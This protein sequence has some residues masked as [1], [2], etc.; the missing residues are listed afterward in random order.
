MTKIEWVA[1]PGTTPETW[2]PVTGCTKISEGC[3]NCYAERMARRLA[4]RFGYPADE[5]F[6]VTLHPSRLG[7]PLKWKKPR[8]IFICSMSDLFHKDVSWSFILDVIAIISRTPQHTYL[9]LTKRASRMYE[10]VRN[11]PQAQLGNIWLGVTAENQAA[12]DERIPL[13]LQTPAAVR[14]VSCEPLLSPVLLEQYLWC[15]EDRPYGMNTLGQIRPPLNWVIV[16]GE[17]GS[18]ARPMHPDWARGIR[19]QCQAAGVKFFFKQWGAWKK[20][21]IDKRGRGDVLVSPREGVIDRLPDPF[22]NDA[23]RDDFKRVVAMSRVGKEA[24]SRLLDGREWNEWPNKTS[25]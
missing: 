3:R 11:M 14:F 22:L 18:G 19:D 21:Q 13:L 1:R 8:T 2:N 4:G 15:L 20:I 25:P 6:R 23:N 7:Q 24:A 9:V 5:P 10:F 12:A 17:S 16:G